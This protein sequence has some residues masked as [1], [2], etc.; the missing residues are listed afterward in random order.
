MLAG[1]LVLLCAIWAIVRWLAIEPRWTRSL[2]HS[3]EEAGFRTSATWAEL[4]DWARLG[5]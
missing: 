4:L 1:L 3:L 5:R 2:T